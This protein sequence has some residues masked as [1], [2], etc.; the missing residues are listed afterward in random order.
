MGAYVGS[1]RLRRAEQI[2]PDWPDAF[3]ILTA[4]GRR[5]GGGVHLLAQ[6]R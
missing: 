4:G 6:R 3:Q 1:L 2:D 5:F